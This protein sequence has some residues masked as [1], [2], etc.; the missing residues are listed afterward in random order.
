MSQS[1]PSSSAI[2]VKTMQAIVCAAYGEAEVLSV[3][4]VVRP[5][6]S[7]GEVL[8]RVHAAG[9]TRGD[10]HLMAGKPYLMRVMGFGFSR[11]ANPVLGLEV[12]GTVVEVGPKV[13]RFKVGDEVFGIGQGT[14]AE[15]TRAREGKLARKPARLSFEQAA[16]LGISGATAVQ[17][18]CDVAQ[19]KAGQRALVIGASGGVGAFV[20]QLLK[21][22]GARVTGACSTAKVAMV[23]ELGA[24]QVIDYSQTD[25]AEQPERY[26]VIFDLGGNSSTSRLKRVLAPE[27]TVVLIGG[28]NDGDWVGGMG[29]NM[30]AALGSMFSRQKF[31]LQLPN[32][33]AADLQ[34]LAKLIDEGA[35]TPALERTYGLAEV[36]AA[37]RELVAGKV[38]GKV[39][40]AVAAV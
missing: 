15:Y 17:S 27:G 6:I 29:R 12:A 36:P 1:Q 23:R 3:G 21:S 30:G 5:S 40:I 13:T 20:V 9:L 26:D 4:A 25:F 7:E 11:P 10:W 31:K 32:E 38:R 33:N 16:V 19:V 2:A 34:R 14:F 8:V 18:V 35:L 24:E 22:L 28:E 39:A 37:M